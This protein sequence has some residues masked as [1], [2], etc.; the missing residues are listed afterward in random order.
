MEIGERIKEL[1]KREKISQADLAKKI[2][3]S[4]GNVGDWERGR[5]KPGS[6]ALISLMN[7]FNVTCDW[8]LTGKE[9]SVAIK[10]E[11]SI[12]S[13]DPSFTL[14]QEEQDMIMKFRQLDRRDRE[15]A[16]G[17]I[18]MKYERTS[19]FKRGTLSTSNNGGTGEE[20][21]THEAV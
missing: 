13:S 16:K 12:Q 17:N 15:D 6:D 18:D 4:S 19:S 21:A 1:R 8:L 7:Y 9:L 5:A 11:E 3:V 14:S 10:E 20:A 2:G